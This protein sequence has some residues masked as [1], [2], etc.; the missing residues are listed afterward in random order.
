[1]ELSLDRR[2]QRLLRRL[3]RYTVYNVA[4]LALIALVALQAARLLYAVVTPVD[5]V[6]AWRA[7]D[8]ADEAGAPSA[9][10]GG[11]DPFFRL[12]DMGGPAVVTALDITLYG[13]RADQASGRGSAIIGLPD[14][15]QASFVVGEEIL[16]G[17]TLRAVA[18]DSITVARGGSDEMVYLDQSTPAETVGTGQPDA[19][20]PPT[21][22]PVPVMPAIG[23]P[24]ALLD[25]TQATPRVQGGAVT[26]VVLQPKGSG[27]AF[28][29][30]GLEP[31]DVLVSVAGRKVADPG[32]ADRLQTLMAQGGEV[33]VEVERGGRVVGLRVKAGQ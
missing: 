16:P 2:A 23:T 30:A 29:R 11:F 20:T 6:G 10:L 22:P 9:L 18:F 1:M 4:E 27:E 3:P 19:A 33:A 12:S 31:G 32:A 7:V 28:R 15:S 8:R 17:V 26:G 21:A 13:T 14:G 24:A 25:E 5:P